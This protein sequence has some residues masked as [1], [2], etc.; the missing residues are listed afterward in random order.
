MSGK[1]KPK[2][3]VGDSVIVEPYG[4]ISSI[5]SVK[6]FEQKW[7]YRLK[8][9][10]EFF[11][12]DQLTIA[13]EKNGL[14]QNQE[15]IPLSYKYHFGDIVKVKG[16]GQ[17]FFIVIGFRIELW[18]Y[19]DTAWED[20]IYELSRMEDGQWLEASEDELIFIADEEKAKMLLKN[21]NYIKK[22]P[23]PQNR[24]KQ[25][26]KSEMA[27]IDFLLDMYNDYQSLYRLFGDE[28][29]HKKMKEIVKKLDAILKN[30][31][32][33]FNKDE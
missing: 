16:Y 28:T 5:E 21:Q 20:I 1:R 27:N 18:R 19:R 10:K 30:Q 3:S 8:G 13:N 22:L 11:L 9:K 33:L 32:Q 29:Y 17:D 15:Y 2:F 14:Y 4:F 23:I 12:E 24:K 7:I 25:P 31:N 26:E 6:Y